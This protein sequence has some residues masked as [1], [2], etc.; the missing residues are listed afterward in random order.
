MRMSPT[1]WPRGH[2]ARAWRARPGGGEDDHRPARPPLWT[3]NTAR[4]VR[5]THV[6]LGWSAVSG[7]GAGGVYSG[8]GP[9]LSSMAVV[10]APGV[11]SIR[12]ET[13]VRLPTTTMM[14]RSSP[15]GAI[16]APRWAV[17]QRAMRCAVLGGLLVTVAC[18]RLATPPAGGAR[19]PRQYVVVAAGHAVGTA[20]FAVEPDGRRVGHFTFN[21]RGRGPEIDTE[22]RV[23]ATGALRWFRATG[24]DYWNAPIDERLDVRAGALR[25][26]SPGADGQAPVGAG[27]Y[28]AVNDLD[29]TLA[30]ALLR[31]GDRRLAL[32]P[33]GEAWIEDEVTR[34]V[35]VAGVARRLRRVAV[36]GLGFQPVLTW[37]DADGR[38][39]GY[40]SAW[41]SLVPAGAE[42]VIPT[43]VADDDAWMSARAARLA[44]DLAHRPPAAGLAITHARL[45]DSER[46][47]VVPDATVIVVGDRITAVGDAATPIPAGAQV[48][49]AHGR[50]LLPGL[51]DMHVHLSD[52]D[53]LIDLA[54]G[55]T[56]VRDLGN[57][58]DR[59][60]AQ[61]DRFEAG[62]EIG[63]RV[64]RAGLI[65][66][67]GELAAP[68]GTQV[69]TPAEATAAVAA[70][71]DAGYAQI[72]LYSSLAP[73]LVPVI[74]AAAHARGL[75]VSGHVPTGMTA[76]DAV[77]A[78]FDELNH[79][80]YLFLQFLAE[81]EDDT[82]TPLRFTRVAERGAGLDLDGA[83]VQAFLDL[84]V[85]R[86][87]VLDPTLAVFE[88]MFRSEPGDP[89][90]V[91]APYYGR[92]PAQV[93]RGARGGGL[94]ADGP[95]RARFRAAHEAML[96]LVKRAWDRHI[97]IVAG[98]DD[99]SGLALAREL[100]LY[101][102]AGIP[103]PEVLA[104]A[105]LGA[106]RVMGRER[107]SGSI[108]VGKQADLVLVDGDPTRDIGAVRAT[109]AVVCRGVVYDPAALFA[110]V[111]MR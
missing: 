5:P 62:A 45:F 37:L 4:N 33:A 92:L 78:G 94:P 69:A 49:D 26:S 23:D 56:T 101:V 73:A 95:A 61:R 32:L 39:F 65:D 10:S 70:F 38:L 20:T 83:P 17:R 3:P 24:H 9:G 42:A 55:V 77:R 29:S 36:A 86:G 76:A 99:A 85:A 14:L 97:P 30:E 106:A 71:A 111:G 84:L 80:N 52:G 109:R 107:D 59:L 25:W 7:P 63:P 54:A 64:V 110:A 105:T 88:V 81:P 11:V 15:G 13:S 74:A 34:E 87:T 89:K 67:P 96:G 28:V 57:D 6:L 58:L 8:E 102:R 46:R 53:G 22:A 51:W 2:G 108:A 44:A 43:L 100:E 41:F 27:H 98:T 82:R 1:S 31:A 103:A 75:R 91:F 18:G 19:A 104:L 66:G 50:T 60:A 12:A 16:V 93:E 40:V 90:P 72:K 21:D 47:A 48:I 35:V 68:T 79:A